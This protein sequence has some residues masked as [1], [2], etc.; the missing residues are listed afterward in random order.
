[1]SSHKCILV[2]CTLVTEG[3]AIFYGD[4]FGETKGSRSQGHIAL[5]SVATVLKE[6]IYG[7]YTAGM[8]KSHA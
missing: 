6:S 3:S 2:L 8:Q 4:S 1:M 7:P 5:A